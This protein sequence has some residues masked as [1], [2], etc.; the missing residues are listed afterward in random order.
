MIALH[1]GINPQNVRTVAVVCRANE[2]RSRIVEAVIRRDHPYVDTRSYGTSIA[3][4]GILDSNLLTLLSAWGLELQT[5]IPRSFKSDL[6]F[7]RSADLVIA[8]DLK[9]YDQIKHL[10]LNT[11]NLTNFAIDAVH[12]P[13]DPV[14]LSP[15]GFLE[16]ISKTINCTFRLLGKVFPLPPKQ[17]NIT[18]TLPR[19]EDSIIS[20][21]SDLCF[22]DASLRKLDPN[23]RLVRNSTYEFQESELFDGSLI[24]SVDK[25]IS[26]YKA[27]FD[28]IQPE[29]TLISKQWAEFL[30]KLAS[31][32]PLTVLTEPLVARNARLWTPYIAS[33]AA[34]SIYYV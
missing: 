21:K 20:F 10:N 15:T 5:H 22:V 9:V 17:F 4:N 8:A 3:K 2:V 30:R 27:K 16:N 11:V 31:L 34:D 28:F 6:D 12:I 7:L 23:D 32:A 29:M 13:I 24:A 26:L 18:V 14:G 19:S 25:N 1:A 33:H